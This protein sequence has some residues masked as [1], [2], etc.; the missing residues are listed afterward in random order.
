MSR[1]WRS[2][3]LWQLA[4]VK[5]R[6]QQKLLQQQG[7]SGSNLTLL[8]QKRNFTSALVSY[9]R[10]P[11]WR[12]RALIPALLELD[13]TQHRFLVCGDATYQEALKAA[14]QGLADPEASVRAAAKTCITPLLLSASDE[15]CRYYSNVFKCL[16][17]PAVRRGGGP[18][19]G[20]P[21]WCRP[22]GGVSGLGALVATAPYSVPAWLP[23]TLTSLALYAN[24]TQP[25]SIRR[26]VERALQE[27]IKT[28]QEGW[29]TIHRGAF[30]EDQL[31]V[32]DTY[33][34]RPAYFA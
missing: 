4:C 7:A 14:L 12:V 27:F 24:A 29:E 11:S 23:E 13:L 31:D 30:S 6:Q 16:A 25:D 34:G 26:E 21:S 20:P 2:C 32:L 3:S 33:K 1:Q 22:L 9:M 18:S 8:Q 15:D 10:H 19:G 17:G 5:L 28:H